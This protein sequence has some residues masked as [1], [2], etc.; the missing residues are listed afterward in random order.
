MAACEKTA[1]GQLPEGDPSWVAA[2]KALIALAHCLVLR[3][4]R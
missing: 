1:M 4:V 3:V 2:E